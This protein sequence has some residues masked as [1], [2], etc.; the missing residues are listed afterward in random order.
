MFASPLCDD[1]TQ[2]NHHQHHHNVNVSFVDLNFAVALLPT[3]RDH[4]GSRLKIPARVLHF[5]G[6]NACPGICAH[7]RTHT[8]CRDVVRHPSVRGMRARPHVIRI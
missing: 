8:L 7:T 5:D 6:A 1:F 3:E 4:G 2:P